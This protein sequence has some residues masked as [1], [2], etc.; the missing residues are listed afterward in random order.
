MYASL[1]TTLR[2]LMRFLIA[3]MM[4]EEGFYV[5]NM[6]NIVE[7]HFS[8]TIEPVQSMGGLLVVL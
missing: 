7:E 8:I 2:I 1:K 4:K 5:Y 6:Y 3:R